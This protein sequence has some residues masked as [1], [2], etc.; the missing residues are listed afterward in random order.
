VDLSAVSPR[1]VAVVDF[2]HAAVDVLLVLL[3]KLL[4][5][6]PIDGCAAIVAPDIT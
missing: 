4:N 1:I 2:K 6:V 5:I 3:Q